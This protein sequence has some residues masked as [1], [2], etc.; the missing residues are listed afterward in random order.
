M[1]KSLNLISQ[2]KSYPDIIVG[3]KVVEDIKAYVQQK[4]AEGAKTFTSKKTVLVKAV[5]GEVGQEV[6]TRPRCSRDGKIYAFD[7]TKSVVKVAGSMIVKNPDGEN[8]I[9]KPNDFANK[10]APTA[11]PGVYEPLGAPI[12]GLRVEEDIC[13]TAPWGSDIFAPK[14]AVLNITNLDNIYSITDMAFAKT[15]TLEQG[16]TVRK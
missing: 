16:T 10:Y 15:Y 11:Q 2:D 7:E 3:F 12:T 4:I 6:D 9:V 5:E 13:F 1:E 14:G 8:Y